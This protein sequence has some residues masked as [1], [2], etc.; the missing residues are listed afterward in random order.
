MVVESDASASV[1][2]GGVRVAVE[3]C[4]HNLNGEKTRVY[5]LSRLSR[6]LSLFLS[7]YWILWWSRPMKTF[8]RIIIHLLPPGGS[9]TALHTSP[10]K[11]INILY[12]QVYYEHHI[13]YN[14]CICVLYLVL[15]VCQESLHGSLSSGFDNLLDVVVLGLK[16]RTNKKRTLIS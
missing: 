15:C 14:A 11:V 7:D 1:E 9:S 12:V 4:G 8:C 5:L 6:G 3:V 10:Q 2:D 16:E 13:Q